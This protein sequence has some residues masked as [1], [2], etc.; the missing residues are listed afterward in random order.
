MSD[1]TITV[2]VPFRYEGD[3]DNL[4]GIGLAY[5]LDALAEHTS[6]GMPEYVSVKIKKTPSATERTS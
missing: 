6:G 3:G 1:Y 5:V 2:K 4:V